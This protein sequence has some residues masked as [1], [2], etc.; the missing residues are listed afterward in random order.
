MRLI[1]INFID[2]EASSEEGKFIHPVC[3]LSFNNNNNNKP[4]VL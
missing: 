3:H 1:N 4:I 2:M